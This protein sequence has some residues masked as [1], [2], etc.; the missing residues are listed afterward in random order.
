MI[1][2]SMRPARTPLLLLS[3][4]SLLLATACTDPAAL[5]GQDRQKT[6]QGALL[7]GLIGAGA[8]ALASDDR[9]KGA[10]IGG[11]IGAAGGAVVGNALDKQAAELRRDLDNDVGINNTG[12]RLTVTMPQ[13]ILFAVDSF[14]IRPGLRQDLFTVADSL[15]RYPDTRVQVVGHTDSDGAASYNQRLS[16]RRAE[17]VANVLLNGGVQP[18]RINAIG[19]GE[20]QPVASNLTAEGKAQNRRVEI[21]IVPTN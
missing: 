15:Q 4:A 3:G 17:T 16:E 5:G 2:T 7:G 21:V 1:R 12:E 8:G 9:A 10:L 13:D 19:R 20:D 11:A 18:S 14:D 6:R